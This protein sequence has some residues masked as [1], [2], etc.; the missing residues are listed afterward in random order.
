V[1]ALRVDGQDGQP[2]A[3]CDYALV[4]PALH[5][6]LTGTAARADDV[7]PLIHSL[8]VVQYGQCVQDGTPSPAAPVPISGKA[9]GATAFT[10]NMHCS[11]QGGTSNGITLTVDT[12]GTCHLDGTVRDGAGLPALKPS[13]RRRPAL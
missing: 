7:S 13:H 9:A 12:D 1:D 3:D 11:M 4:A 10:K 8:A 5:G 2:G 6:T